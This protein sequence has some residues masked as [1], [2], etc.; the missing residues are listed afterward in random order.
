MT[1]ASRRTI[2]LRQ[3]PAEAIQHALPIGIGGCFDGQR[4]AAA[5]M[6]ETDP[7]CMQQH[8]VHAQ[9]DPE[10]AVVVAAAMGGVADHMM[11]DVVQVAADLLVAP[12]LRRNRQQCI[13]LHR[14][15]PHRHLQFRGADRAPAGQCGLGLAL[16]GRIQ[17]VVDLAGR[18]GPAATHREIGLVDIT[19]HELLAEQRGVFLAGRE[20][21]R[22]AGRTI[23]SMGQLQRAAGLL[24]HAVDQ[25]V[26]IG[27]D[28][29]AAVH[30]EARGF[31]DDDY[32]CVVEQNGQGGSH[33]RWVGRAVGRAA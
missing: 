25:I 12:G 3:A 28:Q 8:P 17:R 19:L 14:I 18:G 6:P 23:Q 10:Q 24:A 26:I 13:A 4:R 5:W 2:R 1:A 32:G 9:V 33:R 20:H 30:G 11:R 22:T 29:M 15:A 21:D 7:P 27:A 31:V 16:S